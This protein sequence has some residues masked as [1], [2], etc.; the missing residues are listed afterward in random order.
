MI[1]FCF[2]SAVPI[3]RSL[4]RK[5]QKASVLACDSHRQSA[6]GNRARRR[7]LL[8]SDFIKIRASL[9]PSGLG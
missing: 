2:S 8:R 4:S 3:R 7:F 1:S 9:V 6:T 5:P